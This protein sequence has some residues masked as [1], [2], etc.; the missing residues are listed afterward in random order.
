MSGERLRTFAQ[1]DAY[2]SPWSRFTRIKVLLWVLVWWTLFRPTP[3]YL[4]RWR[5]MLLRLFGAKISGHPFV[6]SSA[7]VKM[8]W[9][10]EMNDRACLA[11]GSEVYNLGRVVLGERCTVAQQVYLCGGTHDFSKRSLPLVVADIIVGEDAFIGA[12]AIVLPGVE[13]HAGALVG[14]GSVVTRDV[15]SWSVVAGN[16]ARVIKTREPLVE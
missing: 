6:A 10:L 8:P 7:I 12:R 14:A 4:Y 5:I 2:S 16:P 3:K 9:N 11:P 13:I 1:P 15:P